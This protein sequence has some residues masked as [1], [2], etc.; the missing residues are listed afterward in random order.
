[1]GFPAGSV[2]KNL[3]VFFFFFLKNLPAVQEMHVRSLG[4]EDP[5]G[6]EMASHSSILA[7]GSPMEKE[8]WQARVHGVARVAHDLVTKP[9]RLV[10]Y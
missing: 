6:K 2:V 10:K 5:L 7:W 3:P 4:W 1:M 8:V 9:P